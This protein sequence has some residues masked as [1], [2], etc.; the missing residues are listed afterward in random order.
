ML[1]IGENKYGKVV[2]TR[3][4]EKEIRN[5]NKYLLERYLRSKQLEGLSSLTLKNYKQNISYLQSAV[6]KRFENMT[7]RDIKNFLY[8]YQ[9]EN[10]I[11][12]ST[13]DDMR[14]VYSSFF[15]F[16]DEEDYI[17][18]NPVKKIHHIKS[19]KSIKKAFS[20]EE[21]IRLQDSCTSKRDRALIDFLYSTGVRVSELCRLNI[22]DIDFN[23]K[24]L[25]VFGKGNK[26]RIVYF[27][28]RTKVHL[29]DY[30]E[31]RD[32]N[33]D[34]L[35]VVSTEP[36]ERLTPAGVEYIVKMIGNKA[37]VK[38]CHPHRFR[39]TLATRLI[40]RGMPIEQVQKLLGHTK[41]DTTLIYAQVDQSNVKSSHERFV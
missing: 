5:H 14:R 35:F 28:S 27:D 11:S 25:I 20:E 15:N 7:T 40:N 37:G 24:E 38:K 21:I 10:K 6:L 19:K 41:I 29:I 9:L 16:L 17:L 13:L 2:L 23:N 22:T 31:S 33:N 30:L 3:I 18:K 12:N 4:N 26:E 8:D 32:D 36:H 39:H 34:A 1:Y